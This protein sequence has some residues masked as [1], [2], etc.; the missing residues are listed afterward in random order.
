M[1]FMFNPFRY[2]DYSAVNAPQWDDSEHAK[3]VKGNQAVASYLSG[4]ILKQ[5]RKKSRL[6]VGFDGYATAIFEEL[7]RFLGRCLFQ[8]GGFKVITLPVA[9]AYKDASILDRQFTEN[10]PIDTR[11]DPPLL[12][13]RLFHGTE[14]VFFDEDRLAEL[15][16]VITEAEANTII[17]VFGNF[18]GTE[19]IL[20]TL[21]MLAYI[22]VIPKNAVLRLKS[23]RVSNIGTSSPR[24]YREIMRRSYYVDFEVSLKLRGTL[25]KSNRIDYYI[26]GNDENNLLLLEWD[27]FKN[28]CDGL[29]KRPFRCK[30]VYNEG[31]WGGYYT[32]VLD[33]F[34]F[35]SI[36]QK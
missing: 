17:L 1:S 22:D 10:L 2:D 18:T 29:V 33:G 25:L 28:A 31:V 35:R 14:E 36:R 3:V 24:T 26:C 9:E 20:K 13:G 19:K 7:V 21:D 27:T 6:V 15:V 4:E 30:P 32:M 12:Y 23:G 16:K 5:A 11:E 8:A 34:S